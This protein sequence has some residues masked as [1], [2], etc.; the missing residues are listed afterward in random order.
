MA[1]ESC[2]GV[3]G[4][5]VGFLYLVNGIIVDLLRLLVFQQHI[6]GESVVGESHEDTVEPHL[7]CVDGLVPI[8]TLV[9]ARLLL[10]L[11][12]ERL[13]SLEILAL[14]IF[15]V[16]ARHKVAG[17]YLVQVVVFELVAAYLALGVD[18]GVGVHLAVLPDFVAAIF[19]ICVE[20][21][22]KFDAHHVAPLGLLGEVKHVRL[23]HALHFGC[24]HPLA[25][26]LEWHL[27]ERQAAVDVQVF[28]VDVARLALHVVA[29]GHAVELAVL[30]VDVIHVD[31]GV[32]CDDLHSIFALLTGDVLKVDVAHCGQIAAAANL[33]VLIVEVDFQHR[34]GAL[35]HGDVACV[36][37]FDHA[38]AAS[39]GLYAY[40][41]LKAGT[42]HLVVLG[43]HVAASAGN[44]TADNHTAVSILHLA[45]ADDDVLARLVPQSSVVVS[46]ALYGNAVVAG[47]EEAVFD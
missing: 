17:A 23:W 27:G 38:A 37:V 10:Q 12:H 7:V 35:S 4:A 1:V 41:S 14:R 3:D 47:V 18:H 26:V 19:K 46:S 13:Q 39:V 20:H 40:H 31:A 11:L 45:V 25:V 34:L 16:H 33:V 5:L 6:G 32:K 36:D 42:V 28:E 8:H 22:L 43:E 15:L 29:F 30:H 2:F 21:G 44:L 9:G 24:R